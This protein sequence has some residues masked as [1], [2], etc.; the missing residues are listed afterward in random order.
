MRKESRQMSAE[1]ALEVLDKAP[2]ITISMADEEGMPYG[3][4]KGWKLYTRI[5]I[6]HSIRNSRRTSRRQ[7]Q[8]V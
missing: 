7:A 4:T 5:Q 6:G 2:Y 3:R 1:W 8:T